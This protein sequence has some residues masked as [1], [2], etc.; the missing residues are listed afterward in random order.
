M[1]AVRDAERR[2]L[3]T[4]ESKS[5]LELAGHDR[6]NS[7][8]AALVFGYCCMAPATIRPAPS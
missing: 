8:M 6:F 4:E 1:R 7:G 2:L 3:E 5:Y